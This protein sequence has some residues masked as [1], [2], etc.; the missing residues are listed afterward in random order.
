MFAY[1][2][3]QVLR[4]S[5]LGKKQTDTYSEPRKDMSEEEWKASGKGK[6]LKC[7]LN[8]SSKPHLELFGKK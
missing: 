5:K 3:L 8:V 2:V 4:P 7:Q 1:K 6:H